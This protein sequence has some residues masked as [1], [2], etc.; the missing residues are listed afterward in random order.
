LSTNDS[1][2]EPLTSTLNGSSP[3]TSD[4]LVLSSNTMSRDVGAIKQKLNVFIHDHNVEQEWILVA[5]IINRLC[6]IMYLFFFSF[7][8]G[9][10]LF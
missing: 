10:H 5:H 2:M 4:P 1:V 3:A 6:F 9:H 7:S 8:I